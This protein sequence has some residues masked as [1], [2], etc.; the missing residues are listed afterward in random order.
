MA[1]TDAKFVPVKN[2]AFRLYCVV[3]D[4]DG[5][6][7]ADADFVGQSA[8]AGKAT[9]SKDGATFVNST[10]NITEVDLVLGVSGIYFIDLTASEMNCDCLVVRFGV[11]APTTAVSPVE[12]LYTEARRINDL[13]YPAVSGRSLAVDASGQVDVRALAAAS[14]AAAT[15]AANAITSTVVQD[16]AFTSA[17][18]VDAFLTSAKIATDAIGSDELAASAV[19]EIVAAVWA[20]AMTEPAAVPGVTASLKAALEWMFVLSRNKRTQTATTEVVRN[21]ADSGTI[22][23]S[24]KADDGT[25][26]TRG[27][28]A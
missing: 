3:R 8:A 16:G 5:E 25:T 19:L 26:F 6:T 4:H 15:F 1:A 7:V 11:S 17:K 27:E 18:F 23:S 24:V 13:A 12:F 21:D 9:L 28:F 2:A 14:I 10:N 22:A 20:Q